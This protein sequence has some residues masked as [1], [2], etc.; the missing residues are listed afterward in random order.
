MVSNAQRE[1]TADELQEKGTYNI[2]SNALAPLPES[3]LA[4]K[5]TI[6]KHN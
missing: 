1:K 6:G 4:Y 3:V 2:L 5:M